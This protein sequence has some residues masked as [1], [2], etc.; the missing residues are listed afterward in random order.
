MWQKI[1]LDTYIDDANC[2]T[3]DVCRKIELTHSEN[4]GNLNL[5]SSHALEFSSINSWN[6][7]FSKCC[8]E[9]F[10][11]TLFFTVTAGSYFNNCTVQCYLFE[12]WFDKVHICQLNNY[13]F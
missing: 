6:Q 8:H 2:N 5:I 4:H 3:L 11:I 12:P 10:S 1:N 13:D 9:N 7:R